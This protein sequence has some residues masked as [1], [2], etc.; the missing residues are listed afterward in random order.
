MPPPLTMTAPLINATTPMP[1]QTLADA[2]E[3]FSPLPMVFVLTDMHEK[4]QFSVPKNRLILGQ[5]WSLTLGYLGDQNRI[6][7]HICLFLGPKMVVF[8]R[9]CPADAGRTW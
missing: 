6:Y 4:R 8:V 5:K 1:K 3:L 9:V 7:D 2:V